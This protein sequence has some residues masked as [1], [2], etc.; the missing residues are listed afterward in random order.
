[1]AIWK[2]IKVHLLLFGTCMQMKES[3]FTLV[4]VTILYNIRHMHHCNL[5]LVSINNKLQI[6]TD[7]PTRQ[8]CE[9]LHE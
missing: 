2:R 6:A 4:I 3:M 7:A 9:K 8:T 1:M 5:E